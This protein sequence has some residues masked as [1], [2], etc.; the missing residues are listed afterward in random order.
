MPNSKKVVMRNMAGLG[1]GVITALILSPS[2]EQESTS[3]TASDRHDKSGSPHEAGSGDTAAGAVHHV[4]TIV[5]RNLND[6]QLF[7]TGY[8]DDFFESTFDNEAV[9]FHE[10]GACDPAGNLSLAGDRDINFQLSDV[11]GTTGDVWP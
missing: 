4:A 1:I 7:Q 6:P 10:G 5:R 3:V 11:D 9:P 2:Q 8:A